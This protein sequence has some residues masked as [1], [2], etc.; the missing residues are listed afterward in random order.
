VGL[1]HIVKSFD[2]DLSF[3]NN[4]IKDMGKMTLDQLNFSIQSIVERDAKLALKIIAADQDIDQL[5]RDI[6]TFAIRM[7][8]LRQPV[9]QDLRHV[10]SAIKVSSHIERIADYASNI[11]RRAINLSEMPKGQAVHAITRMAKLAEEMIK[12][13]IAAYIAGDDK[14][15]L[16]VW[17]R[18]S[19]IDEI[20]V[21]YLR[22]LLT[23]MLEDP[24][25]IGPC[26]ELLF[27]AKNIE[28]IGDHTTNI[29]E[30]VHYFKQGTAFK[31][32]RRKDAVRREMA[33]KN[34]NSATASLKKKPA[35]KKPS[36]PSK[37]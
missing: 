7:I 35:K 2:D 9:A 32:P 26:S 29:A 21:G 8:A 24:R 15:A 14:K 27:V 33:P 31:D 5:E 10:I 34:S 20:Y 28:R 4:K 12:D 37:K 6:D 25:N 1:D 30:M 17:E 22:E 19:E 3:L 23:Y 36:S 16:Q 13:I 18:D 11:A